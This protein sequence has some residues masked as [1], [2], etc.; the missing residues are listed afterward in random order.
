MTAP[1]SARRPRRGVALWVLTLSTF[2]LAG[3]TPGDV[4]GCGGGLANSTLQGDPTEQEYDY[5]EQGLCANLCLRLRECG[6]LCLS[7]R[8]AGPGCVNDSQAAYQQCLRGDLRG[9][10]FLGS[11]PGSVAQCPH[12]CQNYQQRYRG[13]SEQDVQTCGHAVLARSCA[14][15]ADVILDPPSTCLAVCE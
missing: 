15:I 3:P 11:P 8:G 10:I 4:G 6:V 7:L 9:D 13:A 5:F 2:F 14:T 12:R 1:A